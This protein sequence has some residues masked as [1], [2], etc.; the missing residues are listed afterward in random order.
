MTLKLKLIL[1]FVVGLIFFGL[2]L[3][4]P[5]GTLRFW[6]GWVF[7][8]IWFIPGLFF[9]IYFYKHDPALV[10]RRMRRREK[11]KEQK[12][13]MKAAY[14]VFIV[15]YLI[16]GLDFRFGWTRGWAGAVPLWLKIVSLGMVLGGYLITIWV[17]DANRYASSIIVVEAEQQVIS[18]GPYKWVRHP[19]YFGGLIM[20]LFTPTALGSY[21]ALPFFATIIPIL[22]MR[23]TNEEKVLRLELPGYA[24]YCQGTRH[25]LLPFIW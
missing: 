7:L 11:V 23:L 9:S 24:E 19:M 25:R 20:M 1:Q 21:V 10:E 12:L 22:V 4:L 6:E 16:P 3:F 13:V 8:S 17:M 15:A 18:T 14:L 5:A 2:V